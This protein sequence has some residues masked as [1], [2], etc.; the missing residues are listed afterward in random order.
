MTSIQV[1]IFPL[2]ND[3]RLQNE[4]EEVPLTNSR[5]KMSASASSTIDMSAPATLHMLQR[6]PKVHP[7]FTTDRLIEI[8]RENG[9][10]L[11]K[12]ES[13]AKAKSS[14]APSRPVHLASESSATINR[15]K[16]SRAV[17]EE[18]LRML[19]R[20]VTT[21]S[22][23]GKKM[24]GGAKASGSRAAPM[25]AGGGA[26]SGGAGGAGDYGIG[27]LPM[28]AASAA[29]SSSSSSSFSGAAP[30]PLSTASARG[31][32]GGGGGGAFKS[33]ARGTMIKAGVKTGVPPT[34]SGVPDIRDI[35]MYACRDD[36][37]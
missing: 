21:K 14:V 22:T 16:A 13:I 9:H 1:T 20:L 36:Y 31:G 6:P 25:V 11:G 24:G 23:M 37:L 26:G 12:L 17:E 3:Q 32:G 30:P 35:E 28:A 27:G 7:F 18:N 4:Q 10:L 29:A 33:T 5:A 34:R 15:R 8:S 2:L 19:K